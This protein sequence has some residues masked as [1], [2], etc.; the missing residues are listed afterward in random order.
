MEFYINKNA[1]LPKLKLELIKDGRNDFNKFHDKIQ[2]ANITFTMVDIVTGVKK[3]ACKSAGIE[4]VLPKNNCIC[5]EFYLTYQFTPKETSVGGRYA[6]Q[7]EV[8]FLDGSGTL[9]VPIREELFVNVLEG[10]IKK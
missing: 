7:F 10:S 5:E 3:I 6:A 9:I 1:T 8:E 2:N 4:E